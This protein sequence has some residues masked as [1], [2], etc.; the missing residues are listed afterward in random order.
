MAKAVLLDRTSPKEVGQYND[1]VKTYTEML[2]PNEEETVTPGDSVKTM[3]RNF[4]KVSEAFLKK[5]IKIEKPTTIDTESPVDI[6][7]FF[8]NLE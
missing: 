5:D 6:K 1:L 2:R 7:K 3:E 8:E 4:S